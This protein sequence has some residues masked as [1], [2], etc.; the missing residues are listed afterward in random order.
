MDRPEGLTLSNWIDAP[1]NRW[2]F[3]HVREMT[4]SARISRGDGPVTALPRDD[5]SFDD[6]VFEHEGEQVTW[7]RFL[8]ETYSDALVVIHDAKIVNEWYVDGYGPA[9]TH[10]LMSCSKSL[11]ATFLGV[12]VGDGRVDPLATVPGYIPRLRGTAWEGCTVQAVLDMRTGTGFDE[13]DYG[14]PM[15]DGRLIEEVS[16]YRPRTREGL[17][18]DTAAWIEQIENVREHGGVFEY[19]SILSDVL[20]WII[21][22]VTGKPFAVAFSEEV[23]GRI[24]A[25]RD[26]D[27]IVDEAG[28]PVVEG[29]ICTSARD[30]ARFGL[31]CLSGGEIGGR[32]VIPSEWL[33][34]LRARDQDLIDAYVA[35]QGLDPAFPDACYHDQWWVL[36][37]DAGIFSGYGINGQQLLI[38]PP[39]Q[40]VVA[41]FSTW[42]TADSALELQ[43]AGLTA[44]CA[45]LGSHG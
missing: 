13:S 36:D 33:A 17:P 37:P 5:R 7:E 44:L 45:Y 31:M 20:A 12:L 8:T 35:T 29:G 18:S 10:L 14:D 2:G 22:E 25:E 34:R 21:Q 41:K 11:T 9:D 15:S 4:R 38:H 26:A 28:F 24:G 23:W 43:D 1:H 40:T 19:R 6:V 16:G 39:S 30:F 3:W 27:I 42:P 32:R